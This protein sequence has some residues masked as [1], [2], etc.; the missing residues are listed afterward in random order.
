[1]KKLVLIFG[2]I[3]IIFLIASVYGA[4]CNEQGPI[5]KTGFRAWADTYIDYD[6]YPYNDGTCA[7]KNNPIPACGDTSPPE[8]RYSCNAI[9]CNL[10]TAWGSWSSQANCEGG[11]CCENNKCTIKIIFPSPIRISKIQLTHAGASNTPSKI[12]VWFGNKKVWDNKSV[13][14]NGEINDSNPGLVSYVTI[15]ESGWPPNNNKWKVSDIKF[16]Q[17][18]ACATCTANPG[19]CTQNSNCC[20]GN[21]NNLHCCNAGD[22]WDGSLCKTPKKLEQAEFRNSS[23][24]I[25]ATGDIGKS[26]KLWAR[27][28]LK[29]GKRGVFGE[30]HPNY[31]SINNTN[32]DLDLITG[33]FTIALWVK[34]PVIAKQETFMCTNNVS[35]PFDSAN[36][37]PEDFGFWFGE[38]YTWGDG[39]KTVFSYLGTGL[40]AGR[41]QTITEN[42][43]KYIIVKRENNNI[44]Y[45][46]NGILINQYSL[47]SV[48]IRKG[49]ELNIGAWSVYSNKR[50]QDEIWHS[51]YGKMDEIAIWK[52]ALTDSEILNLYSKTSYGTEISSDSDN[53]LLMHMNDIADSSGIGHTGTNNGVRFVDAEIFS[54]DISFQVYKDGAKFGAPILV[55]AGTTEQAWTPTQG[56]TYYFTATVVSTGQIV[57]SG[58]LVV[59]DTTKSYKCINGEQWEVTDSQGGITYIPSYN[60]CLKNGL[61]CCQIELGF[62]CNITNGLCESIP[63]EKRYCWQFND[64]QI[65]CDGCTEAIAVLS[66][67]EG[68]DMGTGFCGN[69]SDYYWYDFNGDTI[70]DK[71]HNEISGC[72][73]LWTDAKGCN[74]SWSL[75]RKCSITN[76]NY[77][78]T[79]ELGTCEYTITNWDEREDGTIYYT[80]TAKWIG[81]GLGKDNGCDGGSK[82]LD[83]SA[84]TS[85]PFFT[86]A[87]IISIAVILVIFYY[88]YMKKHKK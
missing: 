69:V 63:I 55:S 46:I 52:K 22:V 10:D 78:D 43:W 11:E 40:I 24:D 14:V 17:S 87:N 2:F 60:E 50:N 44:K 61:T 84:L 77:N 12:S 20:S 49:A 45:Y 51:F 31:V 7:C 29:L 47:G 8:C 53:V 82:T 80:W 5:N 66:V 9:D 1:M 19:T 73:C 4:V 71:C 56:G 26:V 67:E 27:G 39:N 85:L 88:F 83:Y 62:E 72:E 41:A 59:I 35:G 42:K 25:I 37:P 18:D 57:Q 32:G 68:M 38:G 23:G 79:E 81:E 15:Y 75:K 28:D 33:D 54:E 86:Y 13:P 6:P 16:W 74:P 30:E 21:C 58:T 36:D 70:V 64:T 3:L 65:Q 76:L 34:N 48:N